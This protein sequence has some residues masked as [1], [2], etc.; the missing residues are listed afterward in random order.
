MSNDKNINS[1]EEQRRRKAESFRLNISD[2]YDEDGENTSSEPEEIS[3][4]SGEDVKHQIARESKRSLK[5]MR[6]EEKRENNC[7]SRLKNQVD[8]MELKRPATE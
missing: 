2:N 3:S 7:R 6:K 8:N 1:L 4:Y 5:R